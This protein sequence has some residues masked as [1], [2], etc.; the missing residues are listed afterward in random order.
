MPNSWHTL[1]EERWKLDFP[2]YSK[3]IIQMIQRWCKDRNL[4]LYDICS[5]KN[6][7]PGFIGVDIMPFP[8]V[9]QADLNGKWPFADNSVGCI[10]ATDALE[11]L[12]DKHHTMSEIYRVLAPGGYLISYTPHGLSEGGISDPTHVSFWNSRTFRYY[13][14]AK[15]AQYIGNETIR[16]RPMWDFTTKIDNDLTY[17]TYHAIALKG[18]SEELESRGERRI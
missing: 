13:D 2:V 4:P 1:R 16:F 17:V 8:G 3:H 12:R 6:P 5:W 14:D 9:I 11:H 10:A 7:R 15:T 18:G